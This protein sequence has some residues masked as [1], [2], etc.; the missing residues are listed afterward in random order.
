M[1]RERRGRNCPSP[2][3]PSVNRV[4]QA[5]EVRN[6]DFVVSKRS[7]HR[8]HDGDPDGAA[9]FSGSK[10]CEAHCLRPIIPNVWTLRNRNHFGVGNAPS[11]DPIRY[12]A[13]AVA[14]RRE[15]KMSRAGLHGIIRNEFPARGTFDR[16][17]VHAAL[18][19]RHALM[20]TSPRDKSPLTAN[21][22]NAVFTGSM[23]DISH[24]ARSSP[25]SCWCL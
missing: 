10:Q 25:K 4:I 21:K 6:G 18:C 14:I 5:A 2:P 15:F 20:I 19:S 7:G 8:Q 17:A 12:L 23:P 24:Q 1:G 22:A 13:R 11:T 9:K 3:A 16:I